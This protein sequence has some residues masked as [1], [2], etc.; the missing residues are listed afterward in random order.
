MQIKM[1]MAGLVFA[2][3]GMAGAAYANCVVHYERIAC[4]G[5]EPE[6][7]KKCDG[8]AACDK[9]VKDA[10]SK[11]ACVDVAFKACDNDRLDITKYKKITAD[12]VG[13]PLVGGFNA[14]GKPDAAGTNFCAAERPDMNRCQ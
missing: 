2:S 7:F 5:R 10:T 9:V 4:Q 3:M 1:M 8:K 14:T 13:Q 12:W 11:D 6:S